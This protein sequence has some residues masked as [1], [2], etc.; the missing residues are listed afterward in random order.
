MKNGLL[1]LAVAVLG[2]SVLA[3]AARNPPT[4]GFCS[5]CFREGHTVSNFRLSL[6]RGHLLIHVSPRGPEGHPTIDFGVQKTCDFAT[7]YL[8]TIEISDA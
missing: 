7:R 1:L 8:P 2:T 3:H 5:Q 6:A 4:D